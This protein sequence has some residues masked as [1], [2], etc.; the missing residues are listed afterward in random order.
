MPRFD[1]PICQHTRQGLNATAA[2]QRWKADMSDPTV[3]KD[4]VDAF[5]DDGQPKGK[6][7]RLQKGCIAKACH[8]VPQ[9]YELLVS[10]L[11]NFSKKICL[12][13]NIY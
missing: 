2:E 7:S 6:V 9:S 12:F 3:K 13:T 1:L 11:T 5:Q 10:P 8:Y 4:Q